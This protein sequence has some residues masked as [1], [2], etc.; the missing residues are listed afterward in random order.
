MLPRYKRVPFAPFHPEP[1]KKR[2]EPTGCRFLRPRRRKT[3]GAYVCDE[4]AIMAATCIQQQPLIFRWRTD[5]IKPLGHYQPHQRPRSLKCT[6]FTSFL[7]I[8]TLISQSI[9]FCNRIRQEMIQYSLIQ[10]SFWLRNHMM[11]Y[12]IMVAEPYTRL[13]NQASLVIS[14]EDR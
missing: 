11:G 2:G 10:W 14:E 13:C 5:Q 1:K 12:H 3:H 4:I 6:I 9:G 7:S 8:T